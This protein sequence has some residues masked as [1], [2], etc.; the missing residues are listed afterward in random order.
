VVRKAGKGALEASGRHA[1]RWPASQWR[2]C[3]PARGAVRGRQR[4][5]L[6][7][8]RPIRTAVTS[9]DFRFDS[10][11]IVRRLPCGMPGSPDRA[12][13]ACMA[14]VSYMLHELAGLDAPLSLPAV[15]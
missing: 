11:C 5:R 1:S 7:A 9:S 6:S 12:N 14:A 8:V 4:S 10:R 3:D 15:A 2:R 13:P